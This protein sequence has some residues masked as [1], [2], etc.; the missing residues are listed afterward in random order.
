MKQ[1]DDIAKKPEKTPSSNSSIG[2]R[3][4]MKIGAGVVMASVAGQGTVA[5]VAQTGKIKPES[6]T[7]QSRTAQKSGAAEVKAGDW[8]NLKIGAGYKND[9]GRISGNGPM[10]DTSRKLVSY[11]T[12]FSEANLTAPVLAGLSTLM[13]DTLAAL[14][15][16]LESEPARINARIGK[17]IRGDFKSTIL[18]YGVVTTPEVAAFTNSCMVRHTDYNDGGPPGGHDS[19][20]IPGILAIGEALHSTGPQV[21]AAVALGYEVIEG[22]RAASGGRHGWDVM[23]DGVATAL[24]TGKLFGLDEDRLANALSIGLVPH[25]P[26][27]VTHVG[28][29]SHWKGC[30]SPLAVRD[31]VYAALLAREGMTGPAQPFEAR[32]GLWDNITGPFKEL[33]LPASRDGRLLVEY[34]RYKRFPAELNSQAL[35]GDGIPAIRQWTSAEDIASIDLEMSFSAWQENSDPPKWDPRNRET[36]DHSMPYLIAIGLTDGE[37][38]LSSFTPDRYIEDARLRELMDKI[39]VAANPDFGLDRSRLTVR[40]KTGAVLVKDVFTDLP[41]SADEIV[42]KFNRVCAYKSVSDEQRDRARTTW[43]NLENVQD[44]A[45][46][47]REMANFGKPAPL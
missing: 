33:R 5:Q 12:S 14:I 16:G 19:D 39:T 2:R 8:K 35:L 23:F 17:T 29:L 32:G 45:V 22:L 41:V 7:A 36:A 30:H 42:A 3:D 34:H 37:L 11:V 25:L 21:L 27:N 18:G 38:Y 47:I 9:A 15:A 40:K 20:I 31:G 13:V 24:A 28:A 4:L 44:I 46:P 6:P 10:D 43:A 26:L 1:E